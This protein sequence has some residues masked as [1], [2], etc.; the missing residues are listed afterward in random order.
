MC[1]VLQPVDHSTQEPGKQSRYLLY[2]GF[3]GAEDH[4]G[5]MPE[6][7]TAPRGT[8]DPAIVD[9]C[10]RAVPARQ[11]R[12]SQYI[13]ISFQFDPPEVPPRVP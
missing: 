1:A 5:A 3:S 4:P 13:C 2:L 11:Q 8:T 9:P 12:V 6:K 10:S 7:G